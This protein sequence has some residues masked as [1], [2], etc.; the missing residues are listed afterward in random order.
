MSIATEIQRLQNAKASIK[1]SIENKGVVVSSSD[2]LDDYSAYIDAINISTQEKT[3]TPQ[4]QTHEITADSGYRGLSKVI[5]DGILVD[6]HDS[7]TTSTDSTTAYTKLVP[8]GA[9]KYA[10]LDKLGGMS[11]KCNQLLNIPDVAETTNSYGI[12]IKIE[13]GVIYLNGTATGTHNITLNIAT[14]VLNGTFSCNGFNTT[15]KS[16]CVI[17]LYN[18]NTYVAYLYGYG[19]S[20]RE[21]LSISSNANKILINIASGATLTNAVIKP[22]L[23]SGSTA[24][25]EFQPYFTDIRD[26]AVTS[27]VS[28]GANL[29]D[30]ESAT[31]GKALNTSNGTLTD[32]SE[33]MVSD[34]IEVKPNEQYS[35][36]VSGVQYN[37]CYYDENKIFISGQSKATPY[38]IPYNAHYFRIQAYKTRLD[39]FMIVY[40]TTTPTT[41]KA[42]RGL[43]DTF[44]IPAEVQAL[45]GYGWGINDTCYNYIDYETKKFIQKVGRVKLKDLTWNMTTRY[46]SADPTTFGGALKYYGGS[47]APN[48]LNNLYEVS[49]PN[50]LY[51]QSG[52]QLI[53]SASTAGVIWVRDTS[54]TDATTFKNHF[55]NNDY[56]YYEL[57]TPVETDISAYIDDNFIEV[58]AGGSITANNTYNQAVPSEIT[59]LVEV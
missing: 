45:T 2:T 38:T 35:N 23:V 21:N 40:G 31:V 33:Y 7:Y 51:N 18:G 43:I 46:F 17:N 57:A 5:L 48:F 24:P 9:L 6:A 36:N 4:N 47:I 55:T 27:V 28:E 41:Y 29:F 44:N 59:Y 1:T 34:Y 54:Y 32:S 12:T 3:I 10:N 22:M 11:Y 49:T 42:Y 53:S 26:S 52:D 30:K 56:L 25:T 8:S 50:Y 20:Y 15:D 13:N 14:I 58:E 19:Y 37:V 39:T 16:N